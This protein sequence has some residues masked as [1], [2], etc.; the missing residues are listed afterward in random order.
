[1]SE[2]RG[3]YDV[4]GTASELP[5]GTLVRFTDPAYQAPTPADIRT[6]KEISGMTGR[7]LCALVGVEDQRTWRRWSQEA[8]APGARQMPYSAWRLLLIELGLISA[9]TGNA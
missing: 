6:L 9:S 7:E 2:E 1:M 8:S 3:K 4:A 5:A